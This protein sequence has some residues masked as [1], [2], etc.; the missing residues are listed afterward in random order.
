MNN[1]PEEQ[2]L[3]EFEANIAAYLFDAAELEDMFKEVCLD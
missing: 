3:S 1:Y 2:W